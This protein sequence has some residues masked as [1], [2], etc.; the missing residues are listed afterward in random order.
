MITPDAVADAIKDKLIT[1]KSSLSIKDA[2]VLSEDSDVKGLRPPYAGVI[3]DFEEEA[4]NMTS[5]ATLLDIPVELKILCSSGENKTAALSFREA[6]TIAGK[7]I[8]LLKGPLTVSTEEIIIL[9]RK[10]PFTIVRNAADQ[11]VVQANLY[12]ELKSVG[13]E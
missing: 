8:E 13:E 9:I 4:G 7:V 6:F 10:R 5:D 1:N 2:S 11:C 3:V 12:Y